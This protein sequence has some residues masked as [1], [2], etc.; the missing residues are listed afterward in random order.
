MIIFRRSNGNLVTQL[1][2]SSF[3]IEKRSSVIKRKSVRLLVLFILGVV[4]SITLS[5]KELSQKQ[6]SLLDAVNAKPTD[7]SNY[8]ERT[9][10]L[11]E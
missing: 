7:R 1:L 9:L 8:K 11:W 3:P 5:A 10:A 6:Q 2:T 4:T